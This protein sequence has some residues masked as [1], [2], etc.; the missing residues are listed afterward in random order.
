MPDSTAVRAFLTDS[1]VALA[2]RLTAYAVQ[3]LVPLPEPPD[4]AAARAQARALLGRLG[5]AGWLA[6]IGDLDLRTACLV[7]EALA[8]ASPLADAVFAL[9][10]LGTVPILL[11]GDRELK[12]RWVP[13]AL[14]GRAMASFA[15]TEVEAGSD[16]AAIATTARRDGA[17]YVL[18]GT[19]T[20]ISNAGLADFYTV[21][22]STD[23]T[24]GNKGI[25]AFVVAANTPGLT[26]VR[27]LV[28]SAPHPLG[29]IAFRDC[30]VAAT[31]RL[32]AEG[33]G[34]KLALATLDRLRATVAA[35]ACGMATRALDEAVAHAIRRK[36]FGR[37]LGEFQLIQEKLAR[38]ATDL[39]AARLLTYRAAWEKDGGAERVTLEAAMAKAFATEA[40]QRIVDDAVQILGG[41]GV[42]A[43]HPVDR[44]YRAVRA[45]RIY[46]GTTEIQHLIVAGQLLKRAGA[47]A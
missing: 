6:P 27:P 24:Q 29:E 25:S 46:E 26:F 36:Q 45:L 21:F 15:L 13:A 42:L 10:A 40:A 12:E 16:A 35:A 34:F 38:M 19:K 5:Q 33:D 18:S 17:G 14:A 31:Q 22:A 41:R 4:D 32:G 23:P 9:Q 8:A 30:R 11:A 47:T 1:H 43:S 39:T 44:L 37:T 3:E 7:R 28:L 2:A 20:F